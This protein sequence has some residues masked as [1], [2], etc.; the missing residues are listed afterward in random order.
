MMAVNFKTRE[1]NIRYYEM[2]FIMNDIRFKKWFTDKAFFNRLPIKNMDEEIKKL[3][4]ELLDIL[5]IKEV[6]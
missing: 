4:N 2:D 6:F 3:E 1:I 5:E